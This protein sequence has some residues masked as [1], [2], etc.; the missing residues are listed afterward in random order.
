MSYLTIAV[1]RDP[2]VSTSAGRREER[3][4]TERGMADG[5][6]GRPRASEHPDYGAAYGSAVLLRE[7]EQGRAFLAVAH[8]YG[9]RV[10]GEHTNL[11][12]DFACS[13]EAGPRLVAGFYV[14]NG[15]GACDEAA[16][17]RAVEFLRD[18]RD[19]RD[20]RAMGSRVVNT[21]GEDIG[22]YLQPIQ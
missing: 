19:M 11:G 4:L 6:E 15:P 16:E 5:R 20:M 10:C 12:A 13:C 1:D 22:A 14:A 17:F 8:G 7:V 3:S 2:L 9:C 18:M 21:D